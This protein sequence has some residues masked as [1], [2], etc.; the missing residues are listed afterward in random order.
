MKIQGKQNHMVR[1]ILYTRMYGRQTESAKPLLNLLDILAVDSI[2]CLKVLKFSHSWH[3]A[4]FSLKYLTV[5]FNILEISID[6]TQDI[7]PNRIF[8]RL[9][10]KPMQESNEPHSW[11][12]KEKCFCQFLNIFKQIWQTLECD[13]RY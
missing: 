7:Q 11:Q 10:L 6:T 2:Y 8:T 4:A 12:L 3:K 5:C 9:E 13:T 1:L